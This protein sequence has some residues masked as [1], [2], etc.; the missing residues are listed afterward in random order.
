MTSHFMDSRAH[1]LPSVTTATGDEGSSIMMNGKRVK[2]D[3]PVFEVYGTV[4]ELNACLGVC[5]LY[6][7][8]EYKAKILLIQER[9]FDLGGCIAM[10][11]PPNV[12]ILEM[13]NQL[14][15]W[16]CEIDKKIQQ[17]NCFVLPGG[18]HAASYLHLART[19]ARRAERRLVKAMDEIVGGPKMCPFFNRLSDFLFLLARYENTVNDVEEI[20]YDP[21]K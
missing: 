11:Q 2:K 18:S 3:Q 7:S 17:V 15:E 4:D 12:K 13:V 21:R 9:L 1:E 19:I 6:I 10:D 5:N 8:P 14:E 20:R 16:G